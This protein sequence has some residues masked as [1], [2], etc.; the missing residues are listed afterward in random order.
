MY[1]RQKENKGVHEVFEKGTDSMS[2]PAG[3]RADYIYSNQ[4]KVDTKAEEIIKEVLKDR[5]LNVY[6]TA[7][8]QQVLLEKKQEISTQGITDANIIS[9]RLNIKLDELTQSNL[10]LTDDELKKYL[11][12]ERQNFITALKD[13][14][15]SNESNVDAKTRLKNRID[16]AYPKNKYEL[17][18]DAILTDE[19]IELAISQVKEEIIKA[20]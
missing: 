10:N 2:A 8:V 7:N 14:I 9:E 16:N 3:V 12:S 18:I 15:E 6:S 1:L 11:K 20:L 13:Y 5:I 4:L 19:N 17:K